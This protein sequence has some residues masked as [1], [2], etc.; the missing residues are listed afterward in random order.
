M[1]NSK[2]EEYEININ[3]LKA[4]KTLQNFSVISPSRI[5]NHLNVYYTR[6]QVAWILIQQQPKMILLFVSFNETH[7]LFSY[8][9]CN[10]ISLLFRFVHFTNTSINPSIIL[11]IV[12]F[13]YK[14]SLTKHFL[15]LTLSK[16]YVPNRLKS[17]HPVVRT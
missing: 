15:F 9:L 13:W 10:K 1:L 17:R 11:Y 6:I 8:S 3:D 4:S 16:E 5:T 7:Y 12:Y 2:E 14:L